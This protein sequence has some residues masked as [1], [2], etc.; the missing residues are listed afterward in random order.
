[1]LRA[2]PLRLEWVP[3]RVNRAMTG[4]Q[5]GGIALH[6]PE[7]AARTVRCQAV[8]SSPPEKA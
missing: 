1:M 4:E 8:I 6:P 3:S 2:D 5:R 7:Q